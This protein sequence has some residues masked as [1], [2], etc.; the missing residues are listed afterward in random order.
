MGLAVGMTA[1]TVIVDERICFLKSQ[2]RRVEWNCAYCLRELSGIAAKESIQTAN[3][4]QS[5][6]DFPCIAKVILLYLDL[7]AI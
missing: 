6:N 1:F 4:I 7:Q 5:S 3:S 2:A